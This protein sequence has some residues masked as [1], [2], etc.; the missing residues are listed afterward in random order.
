MMIAVIIGIYL[1]F[2]M[3]ICI[4]SILQIILKVRVWDLLL[5]FQFNEDLPKSMCKTRFYSVFNDLILFSAGY[6]DTQRE[7]PGGH[8]PNHV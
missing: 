8:I 4:L 2:V 3:P 7:C 6:L 5:T 1:V